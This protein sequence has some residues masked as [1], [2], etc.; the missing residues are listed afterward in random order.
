MGQLATSHP[1]GGGLGARIRDNAAMTLEHLHAVLRAVA[2]PRPAGSAVLYEL[3]P[4][5]FF[6]SARTRSLRSRQARALTALRGIDWPVFGTGAVPDPQSA[7]LSGTWVRAAAETWLIPAEPASEALLTRWLS[8]GGYRLY[9]AREPVDPR[10]LP[11]LFR[12]PP[13]DALQAATGN[14]IAAQLDSLPGDREWRILVQ[15]AALPE[16]RAA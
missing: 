15:P 5:W 12:A 16:V 14:G 7:G 3:R 6:L 13:A 2:D 9:L 4:G 11:D 10:V 1:A 8:A